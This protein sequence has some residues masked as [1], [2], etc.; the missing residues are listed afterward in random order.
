[1]YVKEDI[2]DQ[3]IFGNSKFSYNCNALFFSSFSLSGIQNIEDIWDDN[4]HS[5]ELFNSLYDRRNWISECSRIKKAIPQELIRRLKSEP[6]E[7]NTKANLP[8]RI[9][10]S[11]QF[12]KNKKILENSKLRLK[13]IQGYFVANRVPICQNKWDMHFDTELPWKCIWAV[14]YS[15]RANRK[16]KQLQFKL[17]YNIVYT[18]ERLQRMGLSLN[19]SCHFCKEKKTLLH[20][21]VHYKFVDSNLIEVFDKFN[22]FFLENLIYWRKKLKK[23]ICLGY[24]PKFNIEGC[25]LIFIEIIT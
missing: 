19:G 9:K 2:L 5:T 13:E 22:D 8:F 1:L 4:T 15:N 25:S 20:L 16:A 24:L 12:Y 6:V 11:Y 23:N 18:E 21:F 14:I 7:L 10:N 3:N 17:L